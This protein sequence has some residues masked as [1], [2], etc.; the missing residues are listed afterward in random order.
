MRGILAEN[1]VLTELISNDYQRSFFWKSGGIAEVD[2]VIQ[3]GIDVIPIEVKSSK[4]VRS[5]SLTEYR[6]KYSPR[7]A[8]RTSLR[9]MSRHSDEYGEVLEIP[10][11]LI[12]KL[13]AYL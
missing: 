9:D 11:W 6:K 12:W 13:K 2:Y 8:V 1:F 5:R 3:E 4:R 7:I 10:L